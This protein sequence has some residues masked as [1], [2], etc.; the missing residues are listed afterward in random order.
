[1]AAGGFVAPGFEGLVHAF[2]GTVLLR[3]TWRDALVSDP[4]LQP[5]DVQAVE[6][7]NPCR[8]KR[9]TVVA[10]NGPG[11]P[12]STD[13]VPDAELAHRPVAAFDVLHEAL[14]FEGSVSNQGIP[15]PPEQA[16]EVLAMCPDTCK[17][18]TRVV[19]AAAQHRDA[20]D[21][22]RA[23]LRVVARPSL[24]ISVFYGP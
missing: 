6:A 17:L 15:H 16:R 14:S 10:A 1:M 21:E 20:A 22:V 3:A 7:V 12:C 4:E 8:G 13:A 23:S 18:C 11:R 9:C 24:L 2:V 5:P 19:P